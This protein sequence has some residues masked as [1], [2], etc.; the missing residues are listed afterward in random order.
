MRRRGIRITQDVLTY[1]VKRIWNAFQWNR[2]EG[3]D[4]DVREIPFLLRKCVWMRRGV[5]LLLSRI[6]TQTIFGELYGKR[7][8]P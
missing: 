6:I 8:F 2:D 5:T 1:L 4:I 3:E 7:G